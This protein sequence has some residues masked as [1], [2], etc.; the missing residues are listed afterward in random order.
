M[1]LLGSSVH[2]VP[3]EELGEKAAQTWLELDPEVRDRT[4]LLAPTHALRAEINETV[5]EAL[6][7]E[8]VLR[9]KA[10]RIERLVS[11][12]M[13]RAEKADVRNYRDGDTVVFHQDLVNYR[14]K[15]D[16]VLTVAGIE[17]DQVNLLHPDGKPRGIRPAGSIR[18]RLDVYETRPIEIRAGDRIRW[19]RN[20]KART[21]INGERAEVT[22]IGRG[23]VRL[24]LEDGRTLSLREDD[25]Q[26][27]HIDHAWSSTVH[28]AQGITEDG[29][30]AVLDS[31]HRALTDQSTFYVEISRA[32]DRAV[33]LTDNLEQLV[34]VLEANT[35]ERA[36]ALKAID[37]R[38]EP[39]AEEI[40][41]L[42]PEKTPVWT[43][44]EEWA[45]LEAQA[46]REGTTLFLVEGYEALIGR[47]RK[48]ALLPDLPPAI[49]EIVDGLL[50]YDRACRGH[51]A[52]AGEFLGLLDA[53]AV[54]REALEEA[55][56][57]RRCP[58]CGAGGLPGL[59]QYGRAAVDERNGPASGYWR[60]RGRCGKAN[61]RTPRANP[62]TARPRRCGLRV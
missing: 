51:D 55:A 37:E 2:E 56:E 21:L 22:A 60:P 10:L 39:D 24:R 19:T 30:I 12:G 49:Q 11:L 57:A 9:G 38:I 33:V 6:A 27:R 59:A 40:A 1:E 54:K 25:P 8:G 42:L 29:V 28:G 36:T 14:V 35:G 20:D 23:R 53:H 45:A 32:R 47:T 15:K 4:L 44:R 41:R 5:R 61:L 26:L 58:V 43:P 50:A 13:T 17:H 31:S 34:E 3:Y 62:P 46:R 16:E 7:A 52:A 18:Y 48:L